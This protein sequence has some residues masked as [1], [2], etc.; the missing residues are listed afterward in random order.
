MLSAVTRG[1][2]AAPSSLQHVVDRLALL[3][4]VLV[5][6]VH[7]LQQHVGLDHLLQRGAEGGDE[8]A[9]AASG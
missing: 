8:R 1:L 3:D 5:G 4:G 6:R 9:S 7:D 2:S